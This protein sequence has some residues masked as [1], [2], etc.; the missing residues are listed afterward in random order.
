M[1]LYNN[2]HMTILYLAYLNDDP[3]K[4]LFLGPKCAP[5]GGEPPIVVYSEQRQQYNYKCKIVKEK[6]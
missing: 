5:V 4:K 3:E 6:M 1:I 2:A